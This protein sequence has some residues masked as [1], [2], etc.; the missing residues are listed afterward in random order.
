MSYSHS[1]SSE[2]AVNAKLQS[3]LEQSLP[4][5]VNT[6][7]GTRY[8]ENRKPEANLG[9]RNPDMSPISIVSM[10]E[11]PM[12]DTCYTPFQSALPTLNA[13]DDVAS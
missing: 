11:G 8:E 10:C 6:S 9:A 1:S 12:K 4:N 3:A 2:G 7:C 5:S 13:C